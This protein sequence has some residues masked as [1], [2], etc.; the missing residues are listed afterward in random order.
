MANELNI[1]IKLQ[2][3]MSSKLRAIESN[4]EKLTQKMR[5]AGREISQVGTSMM[6][7]G[8]A[9]SGPLL[10]AFRNSEKYSLAVSAQMD[11]LR[12]VTTQF[13]VQVATA[14][15]PVVERLTNT[16]A[17]LLVIYNRISPEHQRMI[18]QGTLLAGVFLTMGGALLAIVGRM[19]RFTGAIVGAAG[20]MAGFAAAHPVFVAIAISLGAV[21]ALM[22]KLK[23]SAVPAL[24]AI[25][26]AGRMVLIGYEKLVLAMLKI[27]ELSARLRLSFGEADYFKKQG[28]AVQSYIDSLQGGMEKIM[29]THKGV[30]S[31]MADDLDAFAAKMKEILG[32]VINPPKVKIDHVVIAFDAMKEVSQKTAGAMSASLGRFFDTTEMRFRTLKEVVT[33]FGKS[34]IDILQQ[35]IAKWIL[36][37]TIG[38]VNPGLASFFHTGGTVRR[39]HTGT[40]AHDEVPIIAQAGEG[41]ISRRGMSAMGDY[42]FG[43]INA[44][45]GGSGGSG[46]TIN[47][48]IV[49]QAWDTQDIVR[50]RAAIEGVIGEAVKNNSTLRKTM[51]RY[52]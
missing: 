36:V 22:A 32:A 6:F 31:G 52:I 24:N 16:L 43:R 39:A 38:A 14:L 46:T 5:S 37:K 42:A 3:E 45:G 20:A 17:A 19:V 48:V 34:M 13:Q 10:L 1:F 28:E 33:D 47:P 35:A 51:R 29:E 27:L 21:I 23:M 4:T 30:L 40:I 2:D 26:I 15:V 50:N 12:N 41:I 7:L 25:E 49:I 44:G 9:M 8:G 11:R 18:L